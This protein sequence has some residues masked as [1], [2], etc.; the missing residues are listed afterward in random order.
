[1]LLKNYETAARERKIRESIP[2]WLDDMGMRELGERWE[3]FLKT[4]NAAPVTTLRTNTLKTTRDQLQNML[5]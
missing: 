1:V 3:D 5:G 4:L 2:D